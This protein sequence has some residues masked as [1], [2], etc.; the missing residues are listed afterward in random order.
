MNEHRAGNDRRPQQRPPRNRNSSSASRRA[1]RRRQIRRNRIIFAVLVLAV[2]AVIVGTIVH[3]VRK[4]QDKETPG[5]SSAP[6]S[7]PAPTPTPTPTP[8]PFIPTWDTTGEEGFPYLV[9]VNRTTQTVTVYEKDDAGNYTVPYTSM[10]CSTG[11]DT[12]EGK[13]HTSNQYDWRLLVDGVYGQYATRID[14]PILFH[15]VPY[16]SQDKADL[17]SEEYNKLGTPASLG[18]V[19]MRVIDCK[20]IYD[21]CPSGSPVVIFDGDSS[22]DPLGNPGFDPIDLTSPNAGWDPT[23]PD[24]QNPW[25]IK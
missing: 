6:I 19:R 3:F 4:P 22:M 7:T 5:S 16:F 21:N 18:C 24:P 12:P 25:N 20:W 15:S 9:A 23:D 14:G 11:I 10:I 13:F 8:Q 17:E 1:A 2:I